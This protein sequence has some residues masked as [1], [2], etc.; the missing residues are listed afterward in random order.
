M[1]DKNLQ[2]IADYYDNQRAAMQ[3]K[4]AKLLTPPSD[5]TGLDLG[6]GTPGDNADIRP[7]GKPAKP[8]PAKTPPK[9]RR[10]LKSLADIP[11]PENL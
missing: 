11:S 3:P 2:E 9:K 6:L 7:I 10:K 4:I 8:L 1:G 5:L